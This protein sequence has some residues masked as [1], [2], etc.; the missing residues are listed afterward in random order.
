M[1]SVDSSWIPV[2]SGRNPPEFLDSGRNP[3][4]LAGISGGMES[5]VKVGDY[6][7]VK[8]KEELIFEIVRF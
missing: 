5:I 3:R 4:N 6:K 7:I 1:F 8:L 2:N